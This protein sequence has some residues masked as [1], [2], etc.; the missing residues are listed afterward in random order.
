MKWFFAPVL[1]LEYTFY[2]PN[3]MTVFSGFDYIN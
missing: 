3:F 2:R 1:I